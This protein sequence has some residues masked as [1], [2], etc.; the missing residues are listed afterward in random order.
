MDYITISKIDLFKT[1]VFS[2]LLTFLAEL[3]V[4]IIENTTR[5]SQVG[6]LVSLEK[7]IE[8]FSLEQCILFFIVI[9]IAIYLYYNPDL[10]NKTGEFLYKYRYHLALT[11]LVFLVLFEINGSSIGGWD[12]TIIN[13][14]HQSI[15]GS[16]RSTQS[17]EWRIFTPFTLSQYLNDFSYFSSIPRASPTDMFAIYGAPIWTILMIFRPFQIGYLFLSPAKGLSFYWISR[18]IALLLVSFE[19]GMLIT[20]RNK[21]LSLAY[22]VMITFSPVVQWWISVNALVEMLIF[23]QLA[24]LLLYHYM[25]TK[26]YRK[27]LIIALGF[28]ISLGGYIFT[29]YPA[30]QIPLGYVFLFLAIWVFLDNYKDFEFNKLDIG[31]ALLSLAI[32]GAGGLYFLHTSNDT[33]EIVRNTLY[34]GGRHFIGGL[35]SSQFKGETG[36]LQSLCNYI[37]S[38]FYPLNLDSAFSSTSGISRLDS[39][40]YDFFPVPLILYLFITFVEKNRDKLLNCLII[41]YILLSVLSIFVFPEYVYKIT[42]ISNTIQRRLILALSLLNVLILFR[43]LSLLRINSNNRH[44]NNIKNNSKI[45]ALISIAIAVAVF[46]LSTSNG[47]GIIGKSL[48]IPVS[49]VSISILG[50]SLFIIFKSSDNKYANLFLVMCILISAMGGGLVN[51][52]E[53]GIGYYDLE[54]VQFVEGLV[55]E[56]PNANW[57]VVGER[58]MQDMFIAAGAHTITSVNT[59]PDFEKWE[60]IDPGHEFEDVYNRY[61]HMNVNLSANESSKFERVPG[62]EDIIS[63]TLNVNDLEKLNVTYIESEQDLSEY[64]NDNVEF[65]KIYSYRNLKIFKVNY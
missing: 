63:L 28:A 22:A 53:S 49:I 21:T 16:A 59:Y 36:F 14:T 7:L 50:I 11:L 5:L 62:R 27:R 33:I 9:F 12:Q 26:D 44:V 34:P 37:N 55:E 41:V 61:A 1:T 20:N 30:W 54:P 48:F 19:M 45:L 23:G 64:S 60:K 47:F 6:K 35:D 38:I 2:L 32:V 8:F 58:E 57:I 51:P 3:Y 56:N 42:F 10:R 43:S 24:V 31:F 13:N 25:K 52:I 29:I 18:L 65:E 17:D 46:F 15:L 40:F 4:V 39:F